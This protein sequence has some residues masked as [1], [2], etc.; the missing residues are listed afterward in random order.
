MGRWMALAWVLAAVPLGAAE[1]TFSGKTETAIETAGAFAFGALERQGY[2]ADAAWEACGFMAQEGV[3]ADKT[4]LA[5]D[6]NVQTAGRWRLTLTAREPALLRRLTLDVAIFNSSGNTQTAGT[7]RT[8]RFRAE[9]AG[10][11]AEA[12][13]DCR[14]AA[15][16]AAQANTVTLDFGGMATLGAGETL[17]LTCERVEERLGCFFALRS[18]AW[19]ETLEVE[20][21]ARVTWPETLT[22]ATVRFAG[23]TLV[24]P[25]DT[26]VCQIRATADS[27]GGTLVVEGALLGEDTG[28]PFVPAFALP[29]G[30]RVEVARRGWLLMDGRLAATV[31][32]T[33]GARLG[34]ATPSGTLTL[35]DL[36][37]IGAP[38]AVQGKVEYFMGR[39]F[40]KTEDAEL[41]PWGRLGFRLLLR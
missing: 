12:V 3:W 33:Q 2:A 18:I 25:E 11:T 28:E 41:V 24:V 7:V 13:A 31:V 22:S 23:G 26:T 39:T 14:G 6:V 40:P 34:A 27:T 20:T 38:I 15:S 35:D 5:P 19:E 17:T 1:V 36:E 30:V 21:G 10:L 29:R 9:A 37:Q 4:L 32:T 8:A 16:L